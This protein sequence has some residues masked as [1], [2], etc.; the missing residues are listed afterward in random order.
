MIQVKHVWNDILNPFR[1]ERAHDEELLT[2]KTINFDFCVLK[3]LFL[4]IRQ[5]KTN[6]SDFMEILL[7]Y[8]S[9]NLVHYDYTL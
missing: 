9:F 7:V 1:Y 5:D 6:H 4:A 8:F 3:I 2:V